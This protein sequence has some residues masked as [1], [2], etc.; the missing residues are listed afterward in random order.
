MPALNHSAQCRMSADGSVMAVLTYGA[1]AYGLWVSTD[2]G[3]TWNH[4]IASSGVNNYSIA[5]SPDGTKILYMGSAGYRYSSNSG[6]SFTSYG[7]GPSDFGVIGC[8]ANNGKIAGI[9]G[10]VVSYGTA[11]SLSTST[12][13]S[14]SQVS[15][16]KQNICCSTDAAK[17]TLT[18]GTDTKAGYTGK[19]LVST[20]YGATW[21]AKKTLSGSDQCLLCAMSDDGTYQLANTIESGT[22]KIYRS[23]DSGNTWTDITSTAAPSE[24]SVYGVAV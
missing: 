11:G 13:A 6:V 5:I 21:T 8:V 23:T 12:L 18:T 24:T 1:A 10:N 17:M 22:H 2:S 4:R 16:A 7:S 20:D 3:A 15:T 9:Y 14:S 19:I